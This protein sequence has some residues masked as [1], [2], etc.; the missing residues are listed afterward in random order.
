MKWYERLVESTVLRFMATFLLACL[1]SLLLLSQCSLALDLTLSV[2]SLVI[3]YNLRDFLKDLHHGVSTRH[4][5]AGWFVLN[6]A[7][8]ALLSAIINALFILHRL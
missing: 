1:W 4:D 5:F 6:A 7:G 2:I 3:V 8:M